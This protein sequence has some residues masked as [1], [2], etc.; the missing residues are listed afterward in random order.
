[1]NPSNPNLSSSL[2]NASSAPS[3][4][5]IVTNE[6]SLTP[7]V[8]RA[9]ARTPDTRLRQIMEALVR[10]SHAFVQETGLTEEEWE[11]GVA[12]L[13]AIGQATGPAKNEG[14]LLSD[15]LGI[16]T[17]VSLQNNQRESGRTAAALLGPFWRANAPRCE[18]GEN[19][20]R[21]DTSG[22]PLMVHGRVTDVDGNPLPNVDIDVWQADPVGYYENQDT[23]QP[24]MNLRG[25]FRTDAEGRYHLRTV[26]PAGYPVPTDGPCG[27]LLRAQ[28]RHPYRPAHI[29]FM[30]SA[31]GY[32]TL[33][34]QVFADDAEHL[35]TDVVFAVLTSLVG[36]FEQTADANGQPSATLEYNFVLEKGEQKFPMPP[37]P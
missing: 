5:G 33:V 32:R 34:T 14:V 13:V 25:L 21:G 3:M 8:L 2:P 10:H 36:R 16:S 20:A 37:I 12:F 1:M 15:I 23:N 4:D 35:N 22:I 30:V 31:P 9:M 24:D 29:H 6:A 7:I 18:S 27:D 17:M 28:Q 26:R 19:I 11:K